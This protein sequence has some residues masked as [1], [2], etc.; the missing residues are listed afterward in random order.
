MTGQQMYD[1]VL[2]KFKRTDKS[3]EAYQAMTDVI[4][5]MRIQF[6]SDK[7]SEEA[8]LSIATVG[9]YI[10]PYPAD[11]GHFIGNIS[12]VNTVDNSSYPPLTNI[13]KQ[14]YD[15]LYFDRLQST[16]QTTGVPQH[17][18]VYG[19]QIFIGPIP[20]SINYRYQINYTTEAFVSIDSTTLDVPFSNK[21]RNILRSGVLAELHNGIENYQEAQFWKQEYLDGLGKVASSEN[22]DKTDE[23]PITYSGI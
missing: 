1:Y 12:F 15:E 2:N 23:E 8:Y 21:H 6:L 19:E 11:M 4:A 16:N 5:D 10:L 13:S 9:G 14:R 22:F 18:C 7:Y 17:F 3:T 20:D